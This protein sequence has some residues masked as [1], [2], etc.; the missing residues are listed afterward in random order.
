[1]E[2][3]CGLSAHQLDDLTA[4]VTHIIHCAGCVA[5][6]TSLNV[7]LAE[8]VTASLNILHF[9]QQCPNL[10]RLVVTSTAYVT[11]NKN[12]PVWEELATLP[13]PAQ[14][15]MDDLHDGKKDSDQIRSETGHPNNYTLAKCLAEH[16]VVQKKGLTPLT[17]VR[18]SIIS[19]SWKYP[20]PGWIDSFAALCGPISA[21]ALGGLKVLHG[22]PSA[23]LDVVPVDTV[24]EC[25]INE[26]FQDLEKNIDHETAPAKIVQCVSTTE[27]GQSTRDIVDDTIEY[28]D[29]PEN[30]VL[31]KPK[32]WYIG[33]DDRLFY[34]YEFFF[35]YL[36]V[37][38]AELRSLMMLDWNGA[39]KA[40][41]T[42]VRLGQVDTHFR[43]FVEHTYDYRC[44][45]KMLPSDFDRKAY[46]QVILRGLRENLLLPLVDKT[47][48]KGR[49]IEAE[50]GGRGRG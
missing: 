1:M 24:A 23:I 37:K 35:Q 9:S 12:G 21:F 18:P 40:R 7:L 3:N 6:D 27:Y 38:M 32:G 46:M 17:I 10:Q 36:P 5:F 20:F 49:A 48:A 33:T 29:Q 28:F 39:A 41:K 44:S 31:Y 47:K 43:Y 26:A 42:L 11:P 13:K 8:N 25:L 22:D 30:I 14:Q 2:P 34:M 16:F 19:A 50:S 45:T 15:I 4:R